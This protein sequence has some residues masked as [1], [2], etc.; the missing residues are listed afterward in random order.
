MALKQPL[1]FENNT[2]SQNADEVRLLVKGLLGGVTGETS[3][4][5][6][7]DHFKVTEKS[8][9]P[10]MSVDVAAGHIF[11]EGS[12]NSAQGTYHLY[13]DAT[14]NVPLSASDPTNPRIDIIYVRLRDSAYDVGFDGDDD[15]EIVVAEGTPAA[16]PVAPT[17]TD[18]DYVELAHVT[19][20][21]NVSAIED[22]DIEDKRVASSVWS[23]PRG[24]VGVTNLSG[25]AGG[26]ETALTGSVVHTAE[27][28]RR[29][30][31]IAQY[32][33]FTSTDQGN[34]TF[35]LKRDG[36]TVATHSSNVGGSSSPDRASGTIVRLEEGISG[37]TT[38][39]ATL[40]CV[41][42]TRSMNTQIGPC[43]IIV[44]DIGGFLT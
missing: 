13:N 7:P 14:V 9:T 28:G 35:R 15:A 18:E 16:V 21:A 36:S 12:R 33:V 25:S 43:Q 41:S 2:T 40:Q 31:V 44:E 8:G 20:G 42:A 23:R 29:Y 32:G 3:G 39:S 34:I 22:A 6:H 10:D 1:F 27:A 19:V 37:S 17:I 38:W 24:F 26:T 5:A 30:K 11:I 4:V